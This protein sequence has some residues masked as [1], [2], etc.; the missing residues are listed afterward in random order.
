MLGEELPG[1]RYA[2]KGD[3]FNHY[4]HRVYNKITHFCF[5]SQD[6]LCS[7][8]FVRVLTGGKAAGVESR[9]LCSSKV[10]FPGSQEGSWGAPLLLAGTTHCWCPL[11]PYALYV[12]LPAEGQEQIFLAYESFDLLR[13]LFLRRQV[14]PKEYFLS[15]EDKQ[16]VDIL[17]CVSGTGIYLVCN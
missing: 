4:I 10:G 14:T 2:L 15:T 17:R 7:L 9:S 12:P 6:S 5:C 11:Q 16:R 3:A 8:C 1:E 13:P